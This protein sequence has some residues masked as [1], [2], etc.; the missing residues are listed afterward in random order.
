MSNLSLTMTTP[1]ILR[2]TFTA[3]AVRLAAR[4]LGRPTRSL[5]QTTWNR[6][7]TSSLSSVRPIKPLTPNSSRWP[8]TEEVN[9]IGEIQELWFILQPALSLHTLSGFVL[10][11]FVPLSPASFCPCFHFD[12]LPQVVQGEGE[13]EGIEMTVAIA[14]L[15][16]GGISTATAKTA[17]MTLTDKRKPL[18]VSPKTG[19]A[20]T[21]AVEIL[22]GVTAVMDS[23]TLEVVS[24]VATETKV[25]RTSSL[26]PTK[27][28]FRMA[29][30]IPHSSP[31]L[32]PN[33][34]HSLCP[35]PCPLLHSHSKRSYICFS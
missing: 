30:A 4:K 19:L 17:A 34:C 18:T 14:T 28:A 1:T 29:W 8:K 11:L 31:P 2:T 13:V 10:P 27:G 21:T 26:V 5:H 23:Q 6:H 3:L 33:R 16:A 9:P 7:R 12:F 24:P 32:T 25:I 15:V 20:V 35:F 22:T